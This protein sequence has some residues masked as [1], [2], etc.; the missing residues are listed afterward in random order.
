M[1]LKLRHCS[2]IATDFPRVFETDSTAQIQ[3]E[4]HRPGYLKFSFTSEKEQ[5]A[6]FSEM[7]Y[8]KGWSMTI[9]GETNSI[10]NVNYVLRGA[11]IPAGKHQ[12]EMQFDP[13]VIKAGFYIQ[14]GTLLLFLIIL[15]VLYRISGN[16]TKTD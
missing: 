3:L 13:H 12:I 11:L 7:Y 9:D 4:E 14:W 10:H 2:A 1:I 15:G 6:V 8:P 16:S 5:F